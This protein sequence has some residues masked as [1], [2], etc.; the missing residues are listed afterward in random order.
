MAGS[1]RQDG[2]IVAINVTPF[3]D[4]ALVL[5]IIFMATANY[6]VNPAI[7]VD[8]PKAAAA[9]EAPET[10]LN[11]VLARDG[12]LFLNGARSTEPVVAER[13]RAASRQ[14]PNVQAVIAADGA[15][16]HESVI[17]LIDLVKLNGVSHF[18]L[19]IERAALNN[20]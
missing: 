6:V 16:R 3:V 4:I 20:P 17:H 8:L 18:A 11:L 19:S 9:G 5:L 15:S 7:E 1:V 13:C 14:N 12:A 2:P 10:T